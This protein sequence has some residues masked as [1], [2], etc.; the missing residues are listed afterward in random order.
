MS[1]IKTGLLIVGW[2]I[3]LSG[4]GVP[5]HHNVPCADQAEQWK[6]PIAEQPDACEELESWWDLFDDPLLDHLI[7]SAFLHNQTL[8]ETF[9]KVCEARALAAAECSRLYPTAVLQPS[10]YKKDYLPQN[11]IPIGPID[12]RFLSVQYNLPVTVNYEVDLWNKVS[13]SCYAGWARADAAEDELA[14]A[15]LVLSTDVASTYFFLRA[16]DTEEELLKD[17]LALRKDS[18]ELTQHRF[19]G[20]LTTKVDVS[21]AQALLA[22]T[23][24]DLEE[25]VRQRAVQENILALLCGLPASDF[26]VAHDP[27]VGLPPQVAADLPSDMLCRRPDIAQAERRLKAIYH[28]M[29][30]SYAN[31]F[32]SLNLTGQVGFSSPLLSNW[33]SW[34]ARLWALAIDVSQTVFDAGRNCALYEVTRYRY[35]QALAR[36]RQA[37]L[38]SFQEVE[39]ALA[40]SYQNQRRLEAIQAEV[41]AAGDASDLIEQRYEDGLI[42]YLEVIDAQRTLLDAQRQEVRLLGARYSDVVQLIKAL[43]GGW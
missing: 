11:P 15:H 33:L 10:M 19:E 6:W 21:R 38:A 13:H 41:M 9:H 37:V 12:F 8:E 16:L 36:Y 42:N 18:F 31:L 28:E 34:H 22:Q 32:P 23:E 39:N 17:T 26:C 29:G 5:L 30:V 35:Q 27:L 43:G 2:L 1:R 20:G 24:A 25:V 14:S 4:C 3:C 7:C 40:N